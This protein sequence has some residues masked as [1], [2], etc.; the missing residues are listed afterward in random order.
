MAACEVEI[1][2]IASTGSDGASVNQGEQCQSRFWFCKS[3]EIRKYE[4]TQTD[5]KKASQVFDELR[6][7]QLFEKAQ[8]NQLIGR[9]WFIVSGT[10]G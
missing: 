9:R 8:S 1:A 10:K 4:Q 3:N 6:M 5:L 7:G 2:R